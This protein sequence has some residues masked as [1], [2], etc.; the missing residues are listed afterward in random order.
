LRDNVKLGNGFRIGN[1]SQSGATLDDRLDRFARLVSQVAQ[2]GEDG[3][4]GQQTRES[5]HETHD[6]G[7]PV[8]FKIINELNFSIIKGIPFNITYR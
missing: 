4:A 2:N 5:V 7:I 1:E 6:R 8:L 3:H